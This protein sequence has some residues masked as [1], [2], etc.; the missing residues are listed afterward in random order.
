MKTFLTTLAVV[1]A[2]SF[3][4]LA[5]G[6]THGSLSELPNATVNAAQPT[7]SGMLIPLNARASAPV[8]ARVRTN[9]EG[10][11]DSG[12]T[13]SASGSAS[14][15]VSGGADAGAGGAGAGAGAGAGIQ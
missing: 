12:T 11:N 4:A 14:G 10:G 5:E 6:D 7:D 2:F 15:S 9:V 13:G 1:A 3:P 8:N